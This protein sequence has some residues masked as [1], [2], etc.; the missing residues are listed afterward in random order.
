MDARRFLV[1]EDDDA[2]ARSLVRLLAPW[3]N[4]TRVATVSDA[5]AA[6][7]PHPDR[8]ALFVD[9]Q[10]PDGSGL[11]VLDRFRRAYPSVPA[12]VITGHSES[13]VINRARD[14]GADYV[15]KPFESERFRRF[16]FA[17]VFDT[18]EALTKSIPPG[19]GRS[20]DAINERPHSS[21]VAREQESPRGG[22]S[23]PP[24]TR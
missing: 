5:M 15:V 3:G 13:S 22:P 21:E 14:L 16:L 19:S 18:V 11:D 23:R 10:L 20:S 1:V 8:T 4:T 6:L 9:V 12:L 2:F 7:A 17:K 24:K